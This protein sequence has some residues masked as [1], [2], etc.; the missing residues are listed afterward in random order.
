MKLSER[1]IQKQ[2]TDWLSLHRIFWY[3]NNVG[4]FKKGKHYIKFGTKGAPDIIVIL[5]GQYCGIEVKGPKYEQSPDQ[6]EFQGKVEGAGGR[7]VLARSLEDVQRG[8][9]RE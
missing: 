2:I 8:L 6:V 3:R 9:S 7:Y 4:A 5:D 1:D